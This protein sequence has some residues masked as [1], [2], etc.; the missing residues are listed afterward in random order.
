MESM[1]G[2][3]LHGFGWI[4]W[5]LIIGLFFYLFGSNAGTNAKSDKTAM[6]ILKERYARDEISKE[7]Y[8]EKVRILS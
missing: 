3:G 7:E 1:I 8:E 4:F 5:L 2:S 6:E